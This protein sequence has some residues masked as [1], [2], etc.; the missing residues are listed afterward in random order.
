MPIKNPVL[1]LSKNST[2]LESETNIKNAVQAE[3]TAGRYPMAIKKSEEEYFGVLYQFKKENGNVK[4]E[5]NSSW[6]PLSTSGYKEPDAVSSDSSNSITKTSL[7]SEYKTMVKKVED[8][9]GFWVGR[10]ET[11]NMNSSN[12]TTTPVTILKGKTEGISGTGVTWYKMYQGQKT[13]K[14]AKLT[15]SASTTSSMIWGSQ[16]N[17]IMIW[18]KDVKNTVNGKYFITNSVGMGN[19]GAISGVNDGYTSTSSPANTGCFEVKNVY[20]LAGNVSDWTLEANYTY[21]RV[22]RGGVYNRTS[23]SYTRADYR[24]FSSPSGSNSLSGSRLTLY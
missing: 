9:G 11:T 6:T 17:Q 22:N 15:K 12:F 14:T 21:G 23:S 8:N 3:I 18:M 2:A 16:W 1:D 19:F 7:Q 13:Y 4:I 5:L 20:D 24:D 10:Y